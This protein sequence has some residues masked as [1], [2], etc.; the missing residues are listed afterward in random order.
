MNEPQHSNRSNKTT[1]L[2]DQ[3]LVNES[4]ET[5]RKILA[6][7]HASGIRPNDPI[8]LVLIVMT[9]AKVAITPLPEK[10]EEI[11]RNLVLF[12]SRIE[13][14]LVQLQ[15]VT[16]NLDIQPYKSGYNPLP[17]TDIWDIAFRAALAGTVVGAFVILALA[18]LFS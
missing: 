2:L 16:Q 4:E 9:H 14:N 1:E 5:K 12:N 18:K 13:S 15:E 11:Q 6:I 17:K 8:F 3:I 7:V 10:L